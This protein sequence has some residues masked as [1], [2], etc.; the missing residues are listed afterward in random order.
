MPFTNPFGLN[1]SIWRILG[2]SAA[3]TYSGWGIWQI[4]SPGPAGLELFGVP[5]KRVTATGQEE[6]DET[7]RYLIP[8]IGA[9]DL[10]IGSAMVYLGYAGKTREM[11][12]VLAAT[13]ILVIVDLVGYYKIWGA[14]WTAFIGVWAG[15]WITAGVK[16]M[17]GA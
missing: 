3:V 11:G 2:A 7:A 5:P 15:T 4:L 1:T 8:I 14:R 13:T 10:T 17:G 16:M 6:V 9:R 12:T